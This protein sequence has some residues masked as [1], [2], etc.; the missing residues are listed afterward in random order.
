MSNDPIKRFVEHGVEASPCSPMEPP[1]ALTTSVE[2]IP[3]E[4]LAA[5]LRAFVEEHYEYEKALN[6]FEKSL[7]EL[8]K[9]GWRFTP[10]ISSG[11]KRFFQ[12]QDESIHNH[13]RKEEKCL[14]PFL[15][16]KF[17]ASGE[18]SPT[19]K[20]VTPVEVME[21]DHLKVGQSTC[22]VFNLLG[23]A[24]R[25]EDAKSRQVLLEHAFNLGQ[26]IVETMRL[27]I[28]KE[29]T[30]IFPLAQQLISE[31]EWRVV[32]RMMEEV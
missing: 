4:D 2:Q 24:P 8:K 3:T 22:L 13:H 15:R 6:V 19:G 29:N 25:L 5:P 16:E 7:L 12:L 10:E 30:V 26:E 21:D 23:L 28:F 14:F 9:N 20:P 17:L 27:H 18:H 11:L 31:D 32:G 1:E